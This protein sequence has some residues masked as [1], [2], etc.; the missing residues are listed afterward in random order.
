MLSYE[1][2]CAILDTHVTPLAHVNVPLATARGRVLAGPLTAAMDMPAFTNSAMD[3]LAVRAADTQAATPEQPVRLRALET[4][5]AGSRALRA[6]SSGNCI[7]I[8]TGAPLPEGADAVVP[9]E[10][11]STDGQDVLV[12]A[13]AAPGDHVRAQGKEAQAGDALQP[14]GTRVTPATLG[15]ASSQG[16]TTLDVYA[17][18]RV[19]ILLTGDEVLRPGSA[20]Q[21]HKI[22]DAA[23]PALEAALTADLMPPVFIDYVGDNPARMKPILDFVLHAVDA[24]LIVGG[25]SMG[26]CD[27]VQDVAR[28][29]GVQ[30]WFWKVAV[31]PGMPLWV[32][33]REGVTVFNLPGNP[34]SVLVSY[35]LFARWFLRQRAGVP[36]ASAHLPHTTAMLTAELRKAHSRREFVRGVLSESDGAGHVA[37]LPQRGSAMLTGMAQANCLIVMPEDCAE[38]RSGDRV[39]VLHL[40]W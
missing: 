23:G 28:A 18:P 37:P 33:A 3:G 25:A 10:H 14:A 40:P 4:V 21:P 32:G 12:N 9:V 8:M 15:V 1:E 27:I 35:C 30:E 34:V 39:D 36:Q 26:T 11:T 29:V 19:A 6:V 31:K 20:P 17:A 13:P 38:C 22:I 5:T 16:L 24:A 2:A 7:R